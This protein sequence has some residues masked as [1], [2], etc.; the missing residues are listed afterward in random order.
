MDAH[1]MRRLARRTNFSYGQIS[2]YVARV[3][4]AVPD[5]VLAYN[6]LEAAAMN[7]DLDIL[8]APQPTPADIN[9]AGIF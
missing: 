3:G 1:V 6:I 2:D 5:D 9:G 7:I 4:A 8:G